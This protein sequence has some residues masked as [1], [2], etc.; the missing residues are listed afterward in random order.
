MDQPLS[1][2]RPRKRR[3]APDDRSRGMSSRGTSSA[4]TKGLDFPPLKRLSAK[5]HAADLAAAIAQAAADPATSLEKLDRLVAIEER[6]AARSAR[7]AFT[8]ALCALQG[9]LPVV[10]ERGEILGRGGKLQSRYA[11]WEDLSEE[12]RP[13]LTRHGFTLSFR[14]E[15]GADHI[16]V[17]AVLSHRGGHCETTSLRLPVDMTGGKNAVQGFGSSTSYGKRYTAQALLNLTS[18]GEDD[19]GAAGGTARV[20]ADDLA[21]VR[22]RLAAAGAD[23][24]RLA[25]YL[26]IPSLEDLA[27]DRLEAARAAIQAFERRA[28]S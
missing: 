19:D 26:G 12:I 13:L 8:R 2:P 23:E 7:V 16:C 25:A 17:T 11:L 24:G 21:D 3:L 28:Q 6:V 4:G 20:G 27:M 10:A 15:A 18:G 5:L 22:A 14:T 1:P 9:V